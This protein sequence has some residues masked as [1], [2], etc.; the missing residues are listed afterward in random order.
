M[1][2]DEVLLHEHLLPELARA[3]EITAGVV[4]GSH[5]SKPWDL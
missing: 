5:M 4:V 2:V 3:S 1:A